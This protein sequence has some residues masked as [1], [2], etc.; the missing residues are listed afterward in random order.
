MTLPDRGHHRRRVVGRADRHDRVRFG[1]PYPV[2]EC[3]TPR[4]SRIRWIQLDRDVRCRRIVVRNDDRSPSRDGW[5]SIAQNI[6]G[7]PP[8]WVMRSSSIMRSA[9]P[10][11]NAAIGTAVPPTIS[12]VIQPALYPKQWKN[13]VTMRPRSPGPS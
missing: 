13:G 1:E 3:S 10:A 9:V 2:N 8:V 4:S 7:D 12:V 6:V 5:S 11:S